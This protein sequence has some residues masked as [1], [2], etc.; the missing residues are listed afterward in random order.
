MKINTEDDN[1]YRRLKTN[2][3]K[4]LKIAGVDLTEDVIIATLF[5]KKSKTLY[6]SIQSPS[7]LIQQT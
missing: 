7:S 3:V 4:T 5:D 6:T 1:T 2:G